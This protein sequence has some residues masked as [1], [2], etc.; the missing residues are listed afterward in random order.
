MQNYVI[1]EQLH[2]IES[3]SEILKCN[4]RV[5]REKAKSGQLKANKKLGKWYVLYSDLIAFVM[6]EG[7]EYGTEEDA[8]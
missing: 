8:D 4:P 3:A 5:L 1:L 6:S 7:T 2:T